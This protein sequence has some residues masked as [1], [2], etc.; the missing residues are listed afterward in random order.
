MERMITPRSREWRSDPELTVA[1]AGRYSSP[2]ARA[3]GLDP[4]SAVQAILDATR[5]LKTRL[6]SYERVLV[7]GLD[8][9]RSGAQMRE[10]VHA[11]PP[12]DRRMGAEVAVTELFEARRNLRRAM[13][14]GLLADGLSVQE[15]AAMFGHPV[16]G[17]SAF[18]AEVAHLV[19]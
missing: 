2:K 19:E 17:I 5:E 8:M 4:E 10:V 6:D 15:I 18:A 1:P 13:V 11:L 9:V 14:A 7:L 16:E 3:A 12:D